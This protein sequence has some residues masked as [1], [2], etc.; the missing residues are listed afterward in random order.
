MNAVSEGKAAPI[1]FADEIQELQER[2][3]DEMS[4]AFFLHVPR[5]KSEY[6]EQTGR[7]LFGK[8]VVDAFPSATLDIEEAGK[9]YSLGRNTACVFHLQRALE[10]GLKVLAKTLALPFDRNSWDAHLKGIE[11]EL[12]RRYKASG[13]RTA[14]ELFF[15]EAA[16]QFGHVKTAWR[17][18][19]MHIE[20]VYSEEIALDILTATRAFMRQLATK[21]KE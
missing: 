14:D 2:I 1:G 9:S 16:A 10:I 3:S 20:K 11:R 6:Y 7:P 12:E 19:T 21:L 4:L 8:E 17:N 13:S 18:P 15:S 5:N